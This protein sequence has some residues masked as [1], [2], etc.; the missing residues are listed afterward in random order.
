MREDDG[1]LRGEGWRPC[2]ILPLGQ[3]SALSLFAPFGRS[4]GTVEDDKAA[5]VITCL[6]CHLEVRVTTD[7][8]GLELS[9]DKQS[10]GLSKWLQQHRLCQWSMAFPK[11][12]N[13][14]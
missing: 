2:S 14:A 13:S 5:R 6:R 7:N 10:T 1:G 12:L 9:Y 8:G 11:P 3:N 4:G